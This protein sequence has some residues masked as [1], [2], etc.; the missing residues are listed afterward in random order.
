MYL[1]TRR[2]RRDPVLEVAWALGLTML[3]AGV[4]LYLVRG[5]TMGLGV[6]M[7][8]VVALFLVAAGAGL[9]LGLWIDR[10]G[11][12]QHPPAGPAKGGRTSRDQAGE[13]DRPECRPP[14]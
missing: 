7:R 6:T 3:V 1:A 14:H 10:S 2:T 5:L 11:P 12:G 9:G 13:P 8:L 4:V